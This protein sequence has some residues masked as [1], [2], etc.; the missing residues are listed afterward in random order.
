MTRTTLTPPTLSGVLDAV[1]ALPLATRYHDAE[2]Q[3]LA[4]L[5]L[6]LARQAHF[7]ADSGGDSDDMVLTNEMRATVCAQAAI[8]VFGIALPAYRHVG[9]VVIHA[10]PLVADNA[11]GSWDGTVRLA[12]ESVAA[13]IADAHDGFCVVLH[14]FAHALDVDRRIVRRGDVP[15]ADRAHD[16]AHFVRSMMSTYADAK[17][18]RPRSRADGGL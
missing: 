18:P 5:A 3:R 13:G 16:P 14:E 11:A 8:L 10:G 9:G 4:E 1:R 2:Q 17:V 6:G 7:D 15:G 12:W